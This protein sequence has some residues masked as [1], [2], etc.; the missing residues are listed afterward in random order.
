MAIAAFE[1]NEMTITD[2]DLCWQVAVA[3]DTSMD[4]VFYVA[5]RTTGIYCRPS[6][7]AKQPKRENVTFFAT[8]QEAEAAGYRACKRCR[9]REVHADARPELVRMA[10]EYLDRDVD[11]DTS[12]APLAEQLGVGPEY[13]R[14]LFKRT[15][16]LTPREY[17][18]SLRAL[19]L[20]QNLR[21]GA[22]VTDA[23]YDAGYP[24]SS[25]LYESASGHLGMTPSLY[26]RGGR[27]LRI[28]FG[29]A[30]SGLG[31]LLVAATG[32]GVC[33]IR[34][35]DTDEELESSLRRE[36]PEAEITRAAAG[37]SE[38]LRELVEY[39][40]GQRIR[41]DLP[42]DVQATAFQARVWRALR[43]IPYGETRSYSA[44]AR[45][46]GSPKAARAVGAACRSNPVP[47]IVP[48]HRVVQENGGLGGY[49]LGLERK[50]SL[51]AMEAAQA[52]KERE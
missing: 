52:G 29:I 32:R 37:V 46:I 6:C 4:G 34:L 1:P 35:A 2:Q 24:S 44:I 14:R 48:C 42:V 16:R 10:C 19:R 28:E 21:N 12:L 40:D 3:K 38:W 13:L 23:I 5:V 31:R 45:E 18:A 41:L 17:A 15:L 25:R 27:G 51:L 39:L 8:L 26:K 7:P 36:F 11:A 20:R 30:N 33:A 9:P 49:A 47:F 43:R 50:R 22:A